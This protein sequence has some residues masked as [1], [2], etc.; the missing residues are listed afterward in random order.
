M[1]PPVVEVLANSG[2]SIL[3][4]RLH[5]LFKIIIKEVLNASS[6]LRILPE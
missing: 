1:L 2:K 5:C 6:A 3:S 4:G